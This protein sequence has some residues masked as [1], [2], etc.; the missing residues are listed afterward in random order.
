MSDGVSPAWGILG[1]VVAFGLIG[2]SMYGCPQYNVYV[3]RTSG[4]AALAKANQ[5]R[6]IQVREAT[7]KRDAAKMLAEAEIERAKGIA[8]ANKIIGD[9]LRDNEG[10]LR[11][12]WI[13]ALREGKDGNTIIYVPTEAG[14]PILESGRISRQHAPVTK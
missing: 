11:W 1:V 6:E 5:N 3:E 13:D 2:G 8:A 4:E 12:L 10:Y 14:L 9:S 7:A